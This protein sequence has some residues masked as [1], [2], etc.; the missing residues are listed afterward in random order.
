MKTDEEYDEVLKELRNEVA[1]RLNLT[2]EARDIIPALDPKVI[3]HYGE[4]F[5][6][7]GA[8]KPT[9]GDTTGGAGN[10]DKNGGFTPEKMHK[11]LDM[12]LGSR[13]SVPTK[14]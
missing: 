4:R 1:L 10:A 13:Y 7:M 8:V 6:A 3:R 14:R 5:A 2:D 12:I 9:T 11:R